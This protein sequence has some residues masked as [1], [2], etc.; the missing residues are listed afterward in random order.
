MITH[1]SFTDTVGMGKKKK[2]TT[3]N[4]SPFLITERLDELSSKK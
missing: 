2:N 4:M 3:F 1:F